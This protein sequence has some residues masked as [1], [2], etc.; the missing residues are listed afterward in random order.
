MDANQP[1][2]TETWDWKQAEART[3]QRALESL[4]LGGSLAHLWQ[5]GKTAGK[6]VRGNLF[7]LAGCSK[8]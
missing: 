4:D 8:T 5:E 2:S 3:L 7:H 6:P 1:V